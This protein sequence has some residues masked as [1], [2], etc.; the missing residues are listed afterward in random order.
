MRKIVIGA[1]L[2]LSLLCHTPAQAL[3]S[4]GVRVDGTALSSADYTTYY[5][6]T[7]VSFRT[8]SE[9][10]DADAAVS[11]E[12]GQAVARTPQTTITARP[13]ALY[14]EV[15]GEPVYV[16]YGVL[17]KEG[18]VFVPV[19]TLA[20]ALNAGVNWETAT[21]TVTVHSGV[22]SSMNVTQYSE[23]DL[24]WLSRIISAESRG[25]PM[26]G[27]IAVGN[28]VLNRVADSE[29]PNRI[30][31]VIFDSRWGGQFTPVKNG[32]IY[33]QP[34]Q[35]SVISAKLVLNGANV[36][37][38]SLYFFAPALTN[39]TWAADN[40]TYVMTIGCHWFYR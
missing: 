15:G 26:K 14:M 3:E 27:Q 21:G 39:N 6:T 1:A 17:S 4:G 19:R 13:G 12:S 8:V 5:S 29:F 24:Y 32:T 22:E 18:R 37:G 11:W 40:R 16:P 35:Q 34:T 30:K 33:Q 36:A 20:S 7:Y 28:V 23:E 9:C 2:C 31:D 25:E 38:K 10:L